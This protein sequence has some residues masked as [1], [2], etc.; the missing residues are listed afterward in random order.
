MDKRQTLISSGEH[1]YA[2]RK[3]GDSYSPD[4]YLEAVDLARASG[5][6]EHYADRV[7]GVDVEELLRGVEEK[8]DV[9]QAAEATLRRRGIDPDVATYQQ[10]ADALV[11]ASS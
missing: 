4:E 1:I 2:V 10:Y 9:V 6:G 5:A 11:E 8:V 3:L 7:L